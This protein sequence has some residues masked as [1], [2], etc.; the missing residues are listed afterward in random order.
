[1]KFSLQGVYKLKG[2]VEVE[3]RIYEIK[4]P[5]NWLVDN[6]YL[7]TFV[8]PNGLSVE[9]HFKYMSDLRRGGVIL[10]VNGQE[11]AD[12]RGDTNTFCL[13]TE[14][15]VNPKL[16]ELVEQAITDLE[17]AELQSDPTGRHARALELQAQGEAKRVSQE[18]ILKKL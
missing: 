15:I 1:M 14:E 6:G 11:I 13:E 5:R 3:G 12:A 18:E 4:K 7:A 9:M 10:C 8:S 17:F 2:P 16:R